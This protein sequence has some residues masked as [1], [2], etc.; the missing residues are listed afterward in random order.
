MVANQTI[1]K[2]EAQAVAEPMDER[3]CFTPRVDIAETN[4]AFVFRADVPGVAAGNID[5]GVEEGVLTIEAKVQ[6]RQSSEQA[7]VLQEYEVGDFRR[8][9]TISTPINPDGITAEL[10]NGELKLTVPKAESAKTRK[11]QIK[12]Q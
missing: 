7:Y 6:P 1:E 12:T 4:D 9:F 3:P 5:V 10:K 11:I 2:Q 8:A